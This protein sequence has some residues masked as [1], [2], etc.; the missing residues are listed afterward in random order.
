MSTTSIEKYPGIPALP[1]TLQWDKDFFHLLLLPILR[2]KS[3]FTSERGQLKEGNTITIK[4]NFS[5][6]VVQTVLALKKKIDKTTYF[7]FI[8]SDVG[9][10]GSKRFYKKLL[11]KIGIYFLNVHHY[12]HMKAITNFCSL[13]V[14]CLYKIVY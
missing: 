11:Q 5:P 7:L 1:T 14:L 6:A 8:F 13:R 3:V 9:A 10:L 12:Y 4:I 2:L